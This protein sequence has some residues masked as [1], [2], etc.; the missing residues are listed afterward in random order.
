MSQQLH[1]RKGAT[2]LSAE[3]LCTMKKM[4]R[5]ITIA[6]LMF[7]ANTYAQDIIIDSC[8]VDDSPLLNQYEI[9]Y[10]QNAIGSYQMENLEEL[11]NKRILFLTNNYGAIHRSKTEFFNKDCKPWF[12]NDDYPSL[13]LIILTAEEKLEIGD[14]DAIVISWSK[15]PVSDRNRKKFIGN[16]INNVYNMH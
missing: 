6:I 14:Y 4:T 13:Q 12:A 8:G 5:T 9:H 16:G 3:P 2:L 15:I 11:T 10:F 7:C 1:S